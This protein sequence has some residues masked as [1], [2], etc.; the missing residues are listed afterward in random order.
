MEY[1]NPLIAPYAKAATKLLQGPVF[2]DQE[3]LWAETNKYRSELTQ[4]FEKIAIELVIDNRD[5][6]AYLKQMPLDD[7]GTTIGLIRR[8]PLTYELT[9]VCVLLREWLMEFELNDT[10]TANLYIT[11]KEFRDRLEMFFKEKAN[12]LKFIKELNRHL[13]SCEKMGFLKLVHK[14]PTNPDEHR[15]EVK[16]IIKARITNEE[17]TRFKKQLEDEFK[18]V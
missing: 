1:P 6:Y 3:E 14:E 9:L 15:Y 7:L 2:E 10:E 17:L 13:E 4:Y 8:I 16:R 18:S 11:P 12:E 5:G